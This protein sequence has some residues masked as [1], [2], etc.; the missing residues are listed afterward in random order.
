MFLIVGLGNPGKE[1][2]YTRHNI[3]FRIVDFFVQQNALPDFKESKK[4]KCLIS[5]G[6]IGKEHVIVIKPQTFMNLS[7][8]SVTSIIDF[9]KIDPIKNLIVI[10]DDADISIGQIKVQKGKSSAGHKGVQSIINELGTKEFTRLRIGI[11]SEEE[12][13]QIIKE[14]HGLEGLVLKDFTEEEESI[15]SDVFNIACQEINTIINNQNP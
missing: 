2:K 9:Y 5:E 15:L 8:K 1:Y 10:G 13:F 6:T 12:S 7:G 14:H 11:D 3:G 4:Y